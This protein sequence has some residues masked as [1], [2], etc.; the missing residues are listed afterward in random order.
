MSSDE[1][2]RPAN[3][4]AA[5]LFFCGRI[6]N[7]TLGRTKLAKLLYYLDFDH[8]EKQGQS[9]TG[10]EYLH[11]A[12]GP[13]PK[14]MRG[15][16]RNLVGVA[17]EEE[18]EQVGPYHQYAYRLRRGQDPGLNVFSKEEL[19][20]LY[21]VSEKWERQTAAR[22]WSP[23]PTE[24]RPGSQPVTT[25]LIPYEYAYYRRRHDAV[26]D[27]EDEEEPQPLIPVD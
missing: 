9:V 16:L 18:V 20:T 21:E 7:G 6:R 19:V 24:R 27:S 4:R 17:I 25:R 22:R 2:Y 11:W 1:R 13:Y 5:I 23:P 26:E 15:E 3:M 10:A 12:R 14:Q 8:Y